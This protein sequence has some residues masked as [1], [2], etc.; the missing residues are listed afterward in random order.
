MKHQ[1][2]HTH[3]IRCGRPCRPGQSQNPEARPFKRAEQGLCADCAVTEFLTCPDVEP[4][5]Q[6][7]LRNGIEILRNPNIQKQ[8]GEILKVGKSDLQADE[9]N[10]DVVIFNWDLPF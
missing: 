9:I 3:C 5:T 7:I 8:F 10:W 1:L 2:N 6:G 4:L